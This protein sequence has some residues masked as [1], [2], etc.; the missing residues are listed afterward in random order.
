MDGWGDCKFFES[1]IELRIDYG[2]GYRIYFGKDGKTLILLLL[3]G[4]KRGQERDIEKAKG[5]WEDYQ[6]RNA[7]RRALR[8]LSV[9]I[10]PKRL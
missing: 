1:L 6:K 10:P 3:G 8:N 7:R 9:P 5:Y 4:T 2:P